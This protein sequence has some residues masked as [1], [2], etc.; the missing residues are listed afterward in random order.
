MKNRKQRTK[1]NSPYSCWEEIIFGVPQGSI[2]VPLLVY[3]F[4]CDLFYMMSDTDFASYSDDNTPYVSADAIDEVIER[5]DT[6]S[7]KFFK[8]FANNQM[9]ENRDKCHL[10]ISKNQNILMHIGPFDIKNT[11]CEKLLG[12]KVDGRLNFNTHLDGI[13]KK[14]SHKIN[15]LSRITPFMNISKRRILQLT[16]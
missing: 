7:V 2:L 10:I 9:K 3:I 6:A 16:I 12:I 15:A 13:I 14:A 4:L 5:L 11:N 1:L 8:W